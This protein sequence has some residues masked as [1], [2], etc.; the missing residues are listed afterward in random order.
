MFFV[1]M[2]LNASWL[3]TTTRKH[4]KKNRNCSPIVV[5]LTTLICSHYTTADLIFWF[6]DC[7]FEIQEACN[8][9]LERYCQ[10]LSNGILHAPKFLEFQFVN[11]KTNLQLFSDCIRVVKRTAMGK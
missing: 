1:F 9:P 2:F 11:H 6:Y 10:D 5:I 7:N 3:H 4:G 8:I